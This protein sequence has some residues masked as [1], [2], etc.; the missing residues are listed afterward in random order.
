MAAQSSPGAGQPQPPASVQP[1]IN[2]ANVAPTPTQI[3]PNLD[4]GGKWVM[5]QPAENITLQL[6]A[7][8][9]QQAIIGIMQKHQELGQNLKLLKTTTKRGKDR[10]VL[11][12]GSF[13]DSEQASLEAKNLPKD[14]RKTWAR[15]MNSIQAELNPTPPAL[16]PHSPSAN[17]PQ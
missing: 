2:V 14:L 17:A 15:K 13:A 7:L 9:D 5:A 12:Y 10:Y 6:M 1:A 8:S 3:P 11:L 4:E 16:P